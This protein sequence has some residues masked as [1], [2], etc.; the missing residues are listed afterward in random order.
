MQASQSA[1][2]ILVTMGC[3]S[4]VGPE[5]AVVAVREARRRGMDC[6]ILGDRGALLAAAETLGL[7]ADGLIGRSASAL[8]LA[9]RI[10][11]LETVAPLSEADRVPGKPTS[12]GG[13]AQ[14]SWVDH[15]TDM[16]TRGDAAA[17]VTG[18]VSK[19]VIAHCGAPGAEVFMGHTEH[20]ARRL[21]AG[22]PVMV[23][24]ADGFAVSLVTTHLPLRDVASHLSVETVLHAIRETIRLL[25]RL[26]CRPP[27]VLV[28]AL[29]PHAG[30]GGLIG[31]E[32][33]TMI[34]PAVEAA[35]SWA[36]EQGMGAVVDGPSPA[37]AAFRIAMGGAYDG[38]VAMYHDQGTIPMKLR[39]FGR[40][41]NVTAG[42]S[43]VRTSV[44]H[45]TAYDIAGKGKAEAGSLLEAIRLADRLV[46]G[47]P[48]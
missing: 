37:E 22:I 4:G 11:V 21:G 44:D 2:A 17:I 35:R 12:A 19:D 42:L 39:F 32:E 33:A 26:G 24:V 34:A 47:T 13:V 28:S 36:L 25:S 1:G 27:R 5:I 23:F 29:N 10:P 3:P 8:P 18:P 45:G 9:H 20:I 15:A 14:L 40:A 41:V 48:G 16:A 30:E 6:R 7:D 46:R 38:V 43:I 31:Q